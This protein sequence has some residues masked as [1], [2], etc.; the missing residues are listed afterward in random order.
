VISFCTTRD[1]E[2][3][4]QFAE[5]DEFL[6]VTIDLFEKP[7]WTNGN[8]QW[9]RDKPRRLSRRGECQYIWAV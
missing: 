3:W 8:A 9:L 2:G 6:S 7:P 1:A 5:E 4:I